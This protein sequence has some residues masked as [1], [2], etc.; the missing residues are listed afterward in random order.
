MRHQ[1]N[2]FHTINQGKKA[3]YFSH[4]LN[5]GVGSL[6][7]VKQVTECYNRMLGCTNQASQ[8]C[9]SS[10][11]A[12][13]NMTRYHIKII[14]D[15]IRSKASLLGLFCGSKCTTYDQWCE[16]YQIICAV[17]LILAIRNVYYFFAF[18]T[19][20]Y[21]IFH[22]TLRY[23]SRQCVVFRVLKHF[24]YVFWDTKR[25]YMEINQTVL[26]VSALYS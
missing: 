16:V 19:T 8:C 24:L 25:I 2:N 15:L 3:R 17:I 1:Q 11:F 18:S 26:P 6:F 14:A 21:F 4:L 10:L 7:I 9:Q 5:A 20:H 23:L 22:Y 13:P 12:K